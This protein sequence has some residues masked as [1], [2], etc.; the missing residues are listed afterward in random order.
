[1]SGLLLAGPRPS[2]LKGEHM[3]NETNT[4]DA[5]PLAEVT[6][7]IPPI[8]T[9]SMSAIPLPPPKHKPKR[10]PRLRKDEYVAL[11]TKQQI[12]LHEKDIEIAQLKAHRNIQITELA[13]AQDFPNA[14]HFVALFVGIICGILICLL[15]R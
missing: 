9:I 8:A 1:M 15:A 13:S 12:E 7:S 5:L 11:Y 6:T 10:T 2:F 3:D 4:G 14:M